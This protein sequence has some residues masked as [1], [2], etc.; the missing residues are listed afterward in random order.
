M[1]KIQLINILLIFYSVVANSQSIT[2][3]SNIPIVEESALNSP[4]EVKTIVLKNGFTIYLNEDHS[5]NDVLGAVVVKGGS[6]YDP[7]N[8]TGIA[9]YLEHMYF[10]G[11]Q[12]I[13]TT[14]F[15]QE[16][17][18]LDSIEFMYNMLPYAKND[19]AYRQRILDKIDY[20]SQRASKY[21]IPGEFD[22]LISQI[23]G[24]ELNAY[25]D[26]EKI[27]YHNSF[28]KENINYWL[29][30]Y[31]ERFDSPVFRLFQSE[32]ETVYEEKN[33]SQDNFF[34]GIYEAVYKNFYPSSIY[35]NQTVLGSIEHLK[36]PSL[37][38][39]KSYSKR[40]YVANNMALILIGDFNSDE[41]INEIK[42]TFGDFREGEK[43]NFKIE[44]ENPIDGR[45]QVNVRITP[46][47]VG[48][49]GF[50]ACK[51]FD[52]DK[53]ATD[54]LISMLSNENN[55]GFLDSLNL[56]NKLMYSTVF[57]DYHSDLGGVFIAYI[58]KIPLKGLKSGENLILKQINRLKTGNYNNDFFEAQKNAL[59]K[60]YELDYES[61]ASRLE[62]IA[63]SFV[64]EKSWREVSYYSDQLRKLTK[65]ELMRIANK[66]FTNNYLALYSKIGFPK[67]TKLKKLDFTKINTDKDVKST[68]ER[69][70]EEN[71]HWKVEPKFIDFN[72]DIK[73]AELKNNATFY[74][75][76]N[77]YNQIFT[78]NIKYYV[79]DYQIKGLT[80]AA[81]YLNFVG[82]VDE[83][84]TEFNKKLQS[85]GSTI[86]AQANEDYL[87][88]E[89][90]G[91]DEHFEQS[92]LLLNQL[93]TNTEVDNKAIAQIV[94]NR[95]LE[96][97]LLIRDIST[98]SSVLTNYALYDNKSRYINRLSL[99]E[100]KKSTGAELIA[101]IQN[102][103]LYKVDYSYVGTITF[104]KVEGIILKNQYMP[105][106]L[107]VGNSPVI[108][109]MR[110]LSG[111]QMFFADDKK[112]VQSH[113]RIIIPSKALQENER[114]GIN[115]FNEYFGNGLNSIVFKEIREYRA[116]AYSAWAS[117]Q[118][119]YKFTEP[120][121]LYCSTSTQNDKAF[122]VLKLFNK[123]IDTMPQDI[124]RA[125]IVRKSLINSINSNLPD[126]RNLYNS[127]SY[128]RLQG[129]MDD[130]RE[131]SYKFY[132][133][134]DLKNINEFYISNIEGKSKI[135]SVIGDSRKID[136]KNTK[137][138]AEFKQVKIKNIYTK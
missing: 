136:M 71:F 52:K 35:G 38:E 36:T 119:P 68:Y 81:S 44:N 11:S 129:I 48:I 77:P 51:K 42:Q 53:A 134:L 120:G 61:S 90:T 101:K 94:K 105:K 83:V 50:R 135:F 4:K 76:K 46:M 55:T 111:N 92:L 96:N 128:W 132:K 113:L 103:L 25:T 91:L 65:E 22:N 79:G 80:Q 14:D 137:Q 110:T 21:A 108:K 133:D 13:G 126:F 24:T 69:K 64:S 49:I 124:E 5:K 10:K 123:L 63:N 37:S 23:G 84:F 62:L 86:F 2:I 106:N 57:S 100:I 27:V 102:A 29:N 130:P 98:K 59:L 82:T 30:L 40:F 74:Y 138:F 89:M 116:M 6:K 107:L 131:K 114:E 87:T 20:F 78:Y 7:K 127:V 26:Y 93:L 70:F 12:H 54:V 60:N 122:Q 66:Y 67:K 17:I 9:H 16:K 72:K 45:T 85:I 95:K 15:K 112:A 32:L 47:P 39:M 99:D 43:Q 33:M 88:I 73:I 18:W 34:N 1:H 56:S 41:V 8:A 97:K 117:F 109:A 28:P 19:D 104:E 125:D 115:T 75:T 118:V 58:P 3:S 31:Y 121:Y